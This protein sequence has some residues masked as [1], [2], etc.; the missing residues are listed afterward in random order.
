MKKMENK[1]NFVHSHK[2]LMG[3]LSK[4]IMAHLY[5]EITMQTSEV[6]Q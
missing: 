6:N 1:L 5:E 2:R 4:Q 3:W